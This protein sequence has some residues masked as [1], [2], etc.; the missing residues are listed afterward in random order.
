M[1]LDSGSTIANGALRGFDDL[2]K[3]VPAFRRF[4]HA[5]AEVMGHMVKIV[6]PTAVADPAVRTSAEHLLH[7]KMHHAFSSNGGLCD[8]WMA[9]FCMPCSAAAG[10]RTFK[11]MKDVHTKR[12]NGL[13]RNKIVK[14]AR[15][16]VNKQAAPREAK[17]RTF[18]RAKG[19]MDQYFSADFAQSFKLLA[20][21]PLAAYTTTGGDEAQPAA[22]VPAA[23]ELDGDSESGISEDD[24]D[25]AGNDDDSDGGSAAAAVEIDDILAPE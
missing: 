9:L 15:L 22:P 19:L 24:D 6:S 20:N 2:C 7:P 14:L 21:N 16:Q 11:K 3:R 5:R 12:R 8:I 13:D 17:L 10:E 23:I 18:Q 4:A 25:L 1:C